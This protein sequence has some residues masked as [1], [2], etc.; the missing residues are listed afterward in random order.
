M[1]LAAA[2]AAVDAALILTLE[3]NYLDQFDQ[4]WLAACIAAHVAV[5]ASYAVP[6]S[7]RRRLRVF[8][9]YVLYC[10]MATAPLLRSKPLL[11]IAAGSMTSV[12]ALYYTHSRR[13]LLT[14]AQ[15]SPLTEWLY[16]PLLA[17][18]LSA[19]AWPARG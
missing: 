18:Q 8:S 3:N 10:A 19:L 11:G 6:P 13:C 5:Y 2:T 4:E 17:L 9:D 15:W 14:D 12:G 7:L 1:L 16:F